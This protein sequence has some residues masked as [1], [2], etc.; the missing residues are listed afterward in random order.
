MANNNNKSNGKYCNATMPKVE[1]I[2]HHNEK[3]WYIQHVLPT[4]L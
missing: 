1:N 2:G 4:D 3:Q